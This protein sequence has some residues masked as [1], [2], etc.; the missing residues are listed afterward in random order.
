[1]S[2][3]IKATILL[4]IILLVAGLCL[5]F[6]IR[7]ESNSNRAD[8]AEANVLVQAKVIQMQA[9]QQ[10]AFN[11]IAGTTETANTTV[12]AKAEETV[13]EY[14]TILKREKSC[15]LP[16][17]AGVSDGLL[18]YTNRLRAS[19]MHSTSGG[20]DAA[21]AGTSATGQLTYCQAVLWIQPLLAAIEKA[22]NQLSAIQQAE[23][24]RQGKTK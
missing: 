22:N 5:F 8:T 15:D 13:I 3:E 17:P 6:G 21:G 18:D 9:D 16:V 7:Y 12:D 10:Q 24:L 23:Q 1:M 19:A 4:L 14:R 11:G 2:A 20:A